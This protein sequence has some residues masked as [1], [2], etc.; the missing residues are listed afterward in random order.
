MEGRKPS[1]MILHHNLQTARELTR[2]S[3]PLF[4]VYVSIPI[5]RS[6]ADKAI[7][8][9]NPEIIFAFGNYTNFS[10]FD[11]LND[12][13]R[14]NPTLTRI[15]ISPQDISPDDVKHMKNGTIDYILKEPVSEKALQDVLQAWK[16]KS[17]PLND[18]ADTDEEPVAV[19][20]A[21]DSGPEGSMVEESVTQPR[22]RAVKRSRCS[23]WLKP[24][25]SH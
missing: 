2:Q 20:S 5:S 18:M 8:D 11:L 17:Q 6:H 10:G 25:I 7:S 21:E 23:I 9:V 4:K 24:M 14:S 3:I 19:Y 22:M 16:T 1:L 15:L 13:R 12:L